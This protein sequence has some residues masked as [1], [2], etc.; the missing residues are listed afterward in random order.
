MCRLILTISFT[1]SEADMPLAIKSRVFGPSEG[2][3]IFWEATAPTP[4]LA[5]EHLFRNR[6]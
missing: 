2:S 6:R 3:V 5:W 4:A 1:A